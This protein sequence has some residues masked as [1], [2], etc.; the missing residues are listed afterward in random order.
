MQLFSPVLKH[1]T[2]K[3]YTTVYQL[4]NNSEKVDSPTLTAFSSCSTSFSHFYVRLMFLSSHL[5][6]TQSCTPFFLVYFSYFLSP[7]NSFIS[8]SVQLCDTTHPSQ[9][10]TSL[11]ELSSLHM[12]RL[13]LQC[14]VKLHNSVH[15]LIIHG[16]I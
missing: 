1:R 2:S 14:T 9:H 4:K 7:S 15:V 11:L 16:I 5:Q 6:A 10:P 3:V 13:L 8:Y 12:I